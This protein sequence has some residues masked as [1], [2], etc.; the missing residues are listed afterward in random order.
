MRPVKREPTVSTRSN[1]NRGGD[2]GGGGGGGAVDGASLR[3]SKR[4]RVARERENSGEE[5]MNEEVGQQD[6]TK[7]RVLR[8]RYLAVI[9]E[10]SGIV[11]LCI[12]GFEMRV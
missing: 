2:G 1:R 5:N 9:H 8:S 7:R 3:D 11:N 4:E 10:I 6:L 12:L